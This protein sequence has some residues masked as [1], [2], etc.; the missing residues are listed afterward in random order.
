MRETLLADKLLVECNRDRERES[1]TSSSQQPAAG[2]SSTAV[3]CNS[4]VIGL[5]LEENQKSGGSFRPIGGQTHKR[6]QKKVT[7][8]NNRILFEIF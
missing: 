4:A 1:I 8:L 2:S 7:E 6:T 3:C 5:H